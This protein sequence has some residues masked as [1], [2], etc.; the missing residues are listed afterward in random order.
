[1]SE[2]SSTIPIEAPAAG[3]VRPPVS[4]DWLAAG[5]GVFVVA[6]ALVGLSGFDSL[7][8]RA[9]ERNRKVS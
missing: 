1:M 5:L 9:H 2:T 4:E 7:G 8:G 3:A 6:L